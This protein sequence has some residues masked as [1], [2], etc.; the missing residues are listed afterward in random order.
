VWGFGRTIAL[1]G[2]IAVQQFR[3]DSGG[4]FVIAAMAAAECSMQFVLPNRTPPPAT[5]EAGLVQIAEYQIEPGQGWKHAMAFS[6]EPKAIAALAFW[7]A[8]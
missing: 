1:R 2:F 8:R 4:V 7:I 3:A 5:R 6:H